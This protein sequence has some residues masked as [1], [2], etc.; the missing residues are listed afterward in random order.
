MK[1][2]LQIGIGLAVAVGLVA[3]L[4]FWVTQGESGTEA[5]ERVK[6]PRPL[7][8]PP[9]DLAAQGRGLLDSLV[10][11]AGQFHLAV[12]RELLPGRCA[13]VLQIRPGGV[14]RIPVAAPV[15]SVPGPVHWTD[16]G[17]LLPQARIS[18]LSA[19]ERSSLLRI[20]SSLMG[21]ALLRE[22]QVQSHGCVF[23]G[24]ELKHLLHWLR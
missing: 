2:G 11:T 17:I 19:S 12:H 3:A 4:Q 1:L 10:G 24:G 7:A 8:P 16:V 18:D 15:Q 9:P 5:A 14:I 22:D 20:W 6:S 23:A 13:P 21:P